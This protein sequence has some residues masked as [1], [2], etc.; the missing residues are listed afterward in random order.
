MTDVF[1]GGTVGCQEFSKNLVLTS[2]ICPGL[3]LYLK[4]HQKHFK[5]FGI[6][7]FRGRAFSFYKGN[8]KN[9]QRK[10]CKKSVLALIS[11]IM[12]QSI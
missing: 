12:A 9:I 2:I 7:L 10:I 8:P 3:Y 5:I 11:Q 4:Q 6:D 1:G